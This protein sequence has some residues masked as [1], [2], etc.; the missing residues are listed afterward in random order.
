MRDDAFNTRFDLYAQASAIADN[1][2]LNIRPAER[3][4]GYKPGNGQNDACNPQQ[5]SPYPPEIS[6]QWACRSTATC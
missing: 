3:S 1:Q 6:M 2:I 5:Q 4:Q